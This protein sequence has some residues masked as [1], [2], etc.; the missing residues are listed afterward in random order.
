MC[1]RDSINN[2]EILT[3]FTQEMLKSGFLAGSQVTACISYNK[4]IIDKY[5]KNVDETFSKIHSCIVKG[6]FPLKGEIKHS[7]FKRLTG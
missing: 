7:T 1:I 4:K 3:F 5:L 2:A 6:K